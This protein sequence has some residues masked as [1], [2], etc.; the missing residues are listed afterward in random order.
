MQGSR[1]CDQDRPEVRAVGQIGLPK[2]IT[3]HLEM[4][5]VNLI[6]LQAVLIQSIHLHIST[7]QIQRIEESRGRIIPFN[8]QIPRAVLLAAGNEDLAEVFGM[9][10]VLTIGQNSD[11]EPLKCICSHADV[12]AALY[13]RD[14]FDRAVAVK[15]GEGEEQAADELAADV[16]G[17]LISARCEL[18]GDGEAAQALLKEE[19]LRA[20]D[21]FVDAQRS[22]KEPVAAGQKRFLT[23]QET[24]GD[25]EAERACALAAGQYSL[26]RH[27]TEVDSANSG[28]IAF[29]GDLCAEDGAPYSWKGTP[30]F[31][32]LQLKVRW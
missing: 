13:G 19:T 10:T 2:S 23:A 31:G 9:G 25:H 26:R 22:R 27:L 29:P 17:D 4:M 12:G 28:G 11:A 6:S 20:A 30:A 21:L 5:P 1:H 32:R 15:K 3:K 7:Q 18:S 8:L 24:D 16:S 14:E